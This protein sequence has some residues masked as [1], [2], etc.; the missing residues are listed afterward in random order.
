MVFQW[1]AGQRDFEAALE[2]PDCARRI[3]LDVLYRLS[4]IKDDHMER[5]LLQGIDVPT[6][7]PI[8]REHD[9]TVPGLECPL[10]PA[11]RMDGKLGREPGQFLLPI[12]EQA[13]RHHNQVR[14]FHPARGLE[15]S[16][17]DR[18]QEADGLDGLAQPHVVRQTGAEPMGIEERQPGIA[19]LLVGT[20]RRVKPL[21]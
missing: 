18:S 13:R 7:Q 5:D 20:Q 8:G 10:T 11:I 17:P 6:D 19:V 2:S 3:R 9:L 4:L 21:R 16:F 1:S 15:A 12:E 14:A